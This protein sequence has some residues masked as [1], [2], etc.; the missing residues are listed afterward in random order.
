ML[1]E[2]RQPEKKLFFPTLSLLEIGATLN[3]GNTVN[4][5]FLKFVCCESEA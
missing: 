4:F 2:L 1:Q 3:G 5:Y